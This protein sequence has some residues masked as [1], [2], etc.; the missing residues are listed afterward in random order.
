M[1]LRNRKFE[2]LVSRHQVYRELEVAASRKLASLSGV[3]RNHGKL[4]EPMCVLKCRF[5]TLLRAKVAPKKTTKK[6]ICSRKKWPIY[7]PT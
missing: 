3:C 1:G 4:S 2:S 7:R 5:E 6:D